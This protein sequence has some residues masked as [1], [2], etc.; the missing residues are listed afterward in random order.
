MASLVA[1]II[2]CSK[3]F[4]EAAAPVGIVFGGMAGID[5]LRKAK[6]LE[7]IFLPKLADLILPDTDLSRQMKQMRYNDSL[8]QYNSKELNIYKEESGIV[9]TFEKNGVINKDEAK[10]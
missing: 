1:R 8:L 3:G 7:P 10:T 5:E 9:D 6:G 2:W 4:C